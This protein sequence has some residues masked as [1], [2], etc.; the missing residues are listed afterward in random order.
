ML[1]G[2]SNAYNHAPT[3]SL[4]QMDR[5]DHKKAEEVRF[6]ADDT[7]LYIHLQIINEYEEEKRSQREHDGLKSLY[8]CSTMNNCLDILQNR[9]SVSI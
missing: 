5:N 9:T 1:E 2:D 3:C 7:V 8:C 6:S 4:T